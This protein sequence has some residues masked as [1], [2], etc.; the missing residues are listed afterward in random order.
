[1]RAGKVW[2]L[3]LVMV[4]AVGAFLAWRQRQ[5]PV[6]VG[7][8]PGLQALGHAPRTVTLVLDAPA[9]KLAAVEVRVVQQGTPRTVLAEDLSGAG[10]RTL[11]KPVTLDAAALKLQEG[12]AE[13]EVDARD[14][15]WRPRPP[16]GPRLVQRFTVDLTPPKLELRT[17][18]GYV[19]HAGAG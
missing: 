6:R 18:T 4:V 7:L 15:L 1:M 14:A 16:R 8:E 9:A 19:K 17:A 11:R 10:A 5:P 2:L 12:P 13:L 3:L